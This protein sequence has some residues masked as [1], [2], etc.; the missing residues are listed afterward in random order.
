MNRVALRAAVAAGVVIAGWLLT[1][2]A[3]TAQQAITLPGEDRW[4]EPRFEE[5]YRVGSLSGEDWEQF[6][7]IHESVAF[8]DSSAY[9]IETDELG[10]YTLPGTIMSGHPGRPWL[11]G[12]FTI[13]HL[14]RSP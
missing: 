10:V 7:S 12:V 5:L 4:L 14:T 13:P 8:S 2:A 11:P 1:A 9:A 6:G 3:L